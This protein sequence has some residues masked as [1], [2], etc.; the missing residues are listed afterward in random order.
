MDFSQI[1][2]MF[3]GVVAVYLTQ[4]S[5]VTWKK[6]ACLFGLVAQPFWAY[7]AYTAGQWGILVMTG[8]YTYSWALGVYNNFLKGKKL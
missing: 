2:I 6:Y 1:V 5:D 3:T 8:F 4:Q 7:S